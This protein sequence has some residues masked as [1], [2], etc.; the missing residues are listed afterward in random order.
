MAKIPKKESIIR[1]EDIIK[2]EFI[3]YNDNERL[4]STIKS[5]NLCLESL[6]KKTLEKIDTI[7]KVIPPSIII[8]ADAKNR[9]LV[10]KVAWDDLI[11]KSKTLLEIFNGKLLPQKITPR[12]L[13]LLGTSE[14]VKKIILD[15]SK[16]I[17]KLETAKEIES[18]LYFIVLIDLVSSTISASQMHPDKNISRIAT[19]IEF[20]KKSINKKSRSKIKP[21]V[22]A[23][24]GLLIIFRNFDDILDWFEKIKKFLKKYNEKCDRDNL[25]KFY[26]MQYKIAVHAGEVFFK[27]N[28][29]IAWAVDQVFKIEK[30]TPTDNFVIS[31]RV[32]E[33][34]LPRLNDGRQ[35][36]SDKIV[37]VILEG[38]E[39][40]RPLWSISVIS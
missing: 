18:G 8:L 32:R 25:S 16:A 9:N 39:N 2:T 37:D 14:S 27:Q 36:H 12:E 4:A 10:L 24:E 23:K 11:T 30:Y 7:L 33:I 5:Y 13:T 15:S 40:K 1:L 6:P 17:K 28:N 22:E 29:P 21:V 35:L 31:D 38:D 20:A 19:F 3:F 34:I 26:T